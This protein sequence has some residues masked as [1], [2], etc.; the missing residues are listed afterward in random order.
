MQTQYAGRGYADFKKDLTEVIIEFLNP[1]QKRY[2]SISS[3]PGELISML[4]KGAT[5]AHKRSQHIL[6]KVHQAIGFIQ[7]DGRQTNYEKQYRG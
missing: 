5:D 3:D 1:I 2:R 6:N 7:Y 4:K